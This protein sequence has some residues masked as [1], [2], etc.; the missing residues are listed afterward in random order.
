[1]PE[2]TVDWQTI[3]RASRV[4]RNSRGVTQAPLPPPVSNYHHNYL[5]DEWSVNYTQTQQR[6]QPDFR[7]ISAYKIFLT[8]KYKHHHKCRCLAIYRCGR[9]NCTRIECNSCE[10]ST[11][12]NQLGT[13]NEP[14]TSIRFTDNTGISWAHIAFGDAVAVQDDVEPARN[15]PINDRHINLHVDYAAAEARVLANLVHDEAALR[16]GDVAENSYEE[17]VRRQESHEI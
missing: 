4:Y 3:E 7:S 15:I 10:N 1:M 16:V 6:L 17:L 14:S 12:L 11:L 5:A 8:S 2:R 13:V 9:E